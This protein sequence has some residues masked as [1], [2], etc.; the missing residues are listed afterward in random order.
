[1]NVMDKLEEFYNY[2]CGY[3]CDGGIFDMGATPEQIRDAI[4]I[5]LSDPVRPFE[6]DS[7]DRESI[8]AVMQ[9]RFGLDY[10]HNQKGA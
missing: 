1:M 6:G 2:C 5:Y 3:Y 10:L 9:S 4:W 8:S 7:M